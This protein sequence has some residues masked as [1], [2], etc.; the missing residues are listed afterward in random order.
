MNVSLT[1]RDQEGNFKTITQ[2]NGKVRKG[3]L[4]PLN[5]SNSGIKKGKAGRNFSKQKQFSSNS[6][7]DI[8][9]NFRNSPYMQDNSNYASLPVHSLANA[10]PKIHFKNRVRDP[11]NDD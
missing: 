3:S 5:V 2:N 9:A 10:S 8:P 1:H 6:N 4:S 7:K 11:N